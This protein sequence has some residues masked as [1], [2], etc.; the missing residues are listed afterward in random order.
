MHSMAEHVLHLEPAA[1][2]Q[3]IW[4]C[5]ACVLRRCLPAACMADHIEGRRKSMICDDRPMMVLVNLRAWAR[6]QRI[7]AMLGRD[8][9]AA[10]TQEH[11]RREKEV[12]AHRGLL[13]DRGHL[14][15]NR[16]VAALGPRRSTARQ[17][18]HE[19]AAGR[20]RWCRAADGIKVGPGGS[21]ERL[22]GMDG[23]DRIRSLGRIKFLEDRAHLCGFLPQPAR[24]T[25]TYL[26]LPNMETRYVGYASVTDKL[27]CFGGSCWWWVGGC[28]SVPLEKSILCTHLGRVSRIDRQSNEYVF[29]GGFE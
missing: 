18:C 29:R 1:C 16:R 9:E 15:D 11:Q 3:D 7:S 10:G 24:Q 17:A 20:P 8:K 26:D 5:S 6:S 13:D 4:V 27:D 28:K 2:E 25:P 23:A 14:G 19:R 12:A 22:L 21:A